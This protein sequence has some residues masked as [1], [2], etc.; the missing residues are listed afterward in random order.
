MEDQKLIKTL[1]KCGHTYHCACRITWGDG[2]CECGHTARAEVVKLK[3]QL[4]ELY[5]AANACSNDFRDVGF[6]LDVTI[7]IL[8]DILNQI[9]EDKV[10][11]EGDDK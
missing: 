5:G 11:G 10:F 3:K 8:E 7:E 1:V 2:E 9:D 4:K 6:V